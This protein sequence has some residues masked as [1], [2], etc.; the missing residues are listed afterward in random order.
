MV[1]LPHPRRRDLVQRR[2]QQVVVQ[3]SGGEPAHLPP[4]QGGQPALCADGGRHPRLRSPSRLGR[5]GHRGLLLL[6]SRHALLY[7]VFHRLNQDF[8]LV[9]TLV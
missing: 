3:V 7:H 2:G 8:F 6:G 4:R 5:A 1:Q 9:L